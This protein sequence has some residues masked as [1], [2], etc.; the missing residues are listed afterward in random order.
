MYQYTCPVCGLTKYVERKSDVRTCCSKSCAAASKALSRE[1]VQPIEKPKTEC[2][3][4]ECVFQPESIN[5]FKRECGKCGWNP[6]VAKAR[7]ERL[8]VTKEYLLPETKDDFGEWIS[9]DERLPR[10]GVQV[11]TYTHTG[12]IMSLHCKDRGW[13]APLNVVVTHW[14]PMPPK[15]EV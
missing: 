9:V 3:V 6:E 13:C 2:H 11:L 5:C 15:P 12:K 8:G 4:G 7:L 14:M 10:D 1:I